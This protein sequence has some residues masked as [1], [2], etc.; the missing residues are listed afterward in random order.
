MGALAN[1]EATP[2]LDTIHSAL[3]ILRSVGIAEEG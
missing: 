1:D 2:R 3:L